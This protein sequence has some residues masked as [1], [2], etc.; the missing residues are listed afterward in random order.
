MTRLID[1]IGWLALIVVLALLLVILWL[2][3]TIVRWRA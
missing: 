2:P 1:A 3:A